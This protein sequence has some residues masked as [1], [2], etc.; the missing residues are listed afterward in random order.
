VY[1]NVH[2]FCDSCTVCEAAKGAY[3]APSGETHSLPVPTKPW[4]SIGM[5]FL[6]P[7]PESQ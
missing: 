6:G 1:S 4:D 7:F 5:D 3:T 2:E